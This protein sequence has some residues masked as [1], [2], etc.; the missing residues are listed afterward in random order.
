MQESR[1]REARAA[2]GYRALQTMEV[3]A[4][5]RDAVSVITGCSGRR[6]SREGR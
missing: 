1:R 4:L 6:R 3:W 2:S 5:T